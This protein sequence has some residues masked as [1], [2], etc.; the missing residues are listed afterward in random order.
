MTDH[1]AK[2]WADPT[3][4]VGNLHAGGGNNV[5]MIGMIRLD[6]DDRRFDQRRGRHFRKL[7]IDNAMPQRL[8]RRDRRPELPALL[9]ICGA[10][11]DHYT[12]QLSQDRYSSCRAFHG[13]YLLRRTSGEL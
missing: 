5:H 3:H 11:R 13:Q 7:H 12:G 9:H 1:R 8:E 6:R 2:C 10:V 4:R